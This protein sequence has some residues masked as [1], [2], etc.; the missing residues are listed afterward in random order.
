MLGGKRLVAIAKG[1]STGRRHRNSA[2]KGTLNDRNVP[3]TAPHPPQSAPRDAGQAHNRVAEQKIVGGSGMSV[4]SA[5]LSGDGPMSQRRC[6]RG[7]WL[8]GQGG[9]ACVW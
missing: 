1:S 7:A 9:R 5:R 6:S 8:P 4:L 2:E 3:F